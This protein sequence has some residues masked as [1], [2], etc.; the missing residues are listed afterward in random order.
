MLKRLELFRGLRPRPPT[1]LI[2]EPDQ[3]LRRLEYRSLSTEYQIIQTSTAEEAV[4]IAARHETGLDLLLT[5]VRLQNT[6]GWQLMELLRL[7]YPSLKVLYLSNSIDVQVKAHTRPS[8]V[9]LL[10]RN[11]FHAGRL[12]QAV[13]DT[14]EHRPDDAPQANESLFSLL[15]GDWANLRTLR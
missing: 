5:E 8:M 3:I 13:R 10:E 15:R 9:L 7:D 12:R 1:I 11:R 2:A 6:D 14:L 4:R